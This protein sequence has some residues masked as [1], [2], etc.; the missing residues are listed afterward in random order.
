MCADAHSVEGMVITTFFCNQDHWLTKL[1][2]SAADAI[3]GEAVLLWQLQEPLTTFMN[4]CEAVMV[5]GE[6]VG[7]VA[8]Y[9]IIA[10]S[11]LAMSVL[12]LIRRSNTVEGPVV[13]D[14]S[15]AAQVR[16]QAISQ[17]DCFTSIPPRESD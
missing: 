5:T 13:C 4:S 16:R 7:S 12:L 17:G 14:G 9:V 1:A 15:Q 8:L 10:R 2:R 3:F 11:V 6:Q